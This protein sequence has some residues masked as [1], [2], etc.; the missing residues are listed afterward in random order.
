MQ[1]EEKRLKKV[2]EIEEEEQH[3]KDRLSV[4][5]SEIIKTQS[6]AEELRKTFL[7]LNR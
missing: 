6:E 2:K 3:L 1:D 4:Q 5:K 7:T